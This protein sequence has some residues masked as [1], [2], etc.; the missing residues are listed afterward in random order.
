MRDPDTDFDFDPDFDG[1]GKE[2]KPSDGGDPETLGRRGET[3]DCTTC[4]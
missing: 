1:D 4:F 2:P 3:A